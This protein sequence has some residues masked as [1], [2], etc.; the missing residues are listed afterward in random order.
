MDIVEVEPTVIAHPTRVDC[1]VV[2]RRLSVDDI[3]ACAD[4]CIA[5]SRA[6]CADTFRFLQKPDPHLETKIA[7]GK[8]AD[9]TNIDR[10]KR[11]VVLQPLAG[12]RR[13]H[14]ITAAI[15]KT[16]HVI[17][18]NL[19]AEA[20]TARTENAALIIE[21]HTRP[22]HN[23]FW[24]LHFVLEKTRLARAEIDAEFLQAAFA[25]LIADGTIERMINKEEFHHAALAFLHQR[26]IC[27]HAYSF[28]DILCAGNLRA[29]QPVDQWFAV[30]AQFRLM[31]GTE[32]WESHFD[33]TH[34]AIARGTELLVITV[35]RNITA[36]LLACL[37]NPRAFWELM[38]HAVDL[39]VQHGD[40]WSW[41]GHYI[42]VLVVVLVLLIE[43]DR[44]QLRARDFIF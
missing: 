27:P 9:R 42:F 6:A 44:S 19:L 11:I 3:F 34:S 43:R 14:G 18:R 22:E 41:F 26:R 7:G 29:G 15:N 12:M 25:G 35:A 39:D 33:Q 20:N 21:R 16:E 36:G 37:D 5:T 40:G 17:L 38:P 1:I 23:I 13:Q 10:V 4:N 30:S 8:R 31:I 32:S 28:G 24:L 2:A